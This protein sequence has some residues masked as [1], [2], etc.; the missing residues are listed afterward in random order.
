MVNQQFATAVHVM[1][2]LGYYDSYAKKDDT[3][4]NSEDLAISV[5]TNPVVIRRILGSLA[6]AHLVKTARGKTGGVS[7]ATSPNQMTL[8][9]IYEALA[10]SEKISPHNK[11]PYKECAVSCEIHN[12]MSSVCS[13]VHQATL[14]FLQT[15][16]LS[17]L[18]KIV[19]KFHKTK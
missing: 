7:L 9:D 2:L 5:G 11:T 13:G 6:K 18:V 4:L 16:K 8:R 15:K 3:I 1:V 19:H 14:K 12:I 17:D 10:V